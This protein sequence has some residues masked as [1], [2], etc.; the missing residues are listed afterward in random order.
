MA[1]DG[2]PGTVGGA[3]GGGAVGGGAVGGGAVGGAVGGGVGG[4]VTGVVVVGVVVVVVVVV[5]VVVVVTAAVVLVELVV[6]VVVEVGELND[7]PSSPP[8]PAATSERATTRANRWLLTVYEGTAPGPV[9][10]EALVR[11]R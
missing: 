4:A 5:F 9:T 10:G 11:Y 6:A 1:C 8:Q 3:V 7:E 2:A